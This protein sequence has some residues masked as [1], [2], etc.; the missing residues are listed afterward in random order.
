[1]GVGGGDWGRGGD[2]GEMSKMS[3]QL[4]KTAVLCIN[5]GTPET[6]ETGNVRRYLKQFLSDPRVVDISWLGR[7]LLL[8]L[9]I[10]VLKKSSS[11]NII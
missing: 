4:S 9:F 1:M 10:K 2:R 5:I 3:E 7:Q 8:N 11:K 6:P